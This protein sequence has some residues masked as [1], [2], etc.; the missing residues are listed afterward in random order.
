MKDHSKLR[1]AV[2]QLLSEAIG[3]NLGYILT[4]RSGTDTFYR[5]GGDNVVFYD[6]EI[7]YID[8]EFELYFQEANP[9]G[10]D[11]WVEG[12]I[13]PKFSFDEDL[14]FL[15]QDPVVSSNDVGATIV[16]A[17]SEAAREIQDYDQ[18][19]YSKE[20]KGIRVGS[21]DHEDLLPVLENA[22]QAAGFKRNVTAP[23]SALARFFAGNDKGVLYEMP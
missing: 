10:R 23:S 3:S 13:R 11:S 19:R 12:V 7:D 14:S 17:C 5:T 20:V 2:R 22:F 15:G 8:E 6:I 9:D 18:D 4:R 1:K 21:Y 16:A